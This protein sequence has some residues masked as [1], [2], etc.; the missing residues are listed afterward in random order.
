MML[1]SFLLFF[2]TSKQFS[3][4]YVSVTL[5]FCFFFITTPDRRLLK[6]LI[7]SKIIRNRVFGCHLLPDWRQMAIENIIAFFM[8]RVR[9]LLRAFSIAAYPLFYTKYLY[10]RSDTVYPNLFHNSRPICQWPLGTYYIYKTKVAKF[11]GIKS[12]SR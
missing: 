1:V 10:M 8:I 3:Y 12:L 9:R 4:V 7:L 6:T 5:S 2:Y 11:Y